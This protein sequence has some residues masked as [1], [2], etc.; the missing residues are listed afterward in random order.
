MPH[1]C[2][3]AYR[4]ATTTSAKA[5]GGA[6]IRHKLQESMVSIPPHCG[7][8]DG[9]RTMRTQ[10]LMLALMTAALLTACTEK[11][12]AEADRDIAKAQQKATQDVAEASKKAAEQVNEAKQKLDAAQAQATADVA[13]ANATAGEKIN[14]ATADATSA[15][16]AA[17]KDLASVQSDAFQKDAKAR[18][19]LAVA[20]AEADYKVAS[21]QCTA[22]PSGQQ[23]SCKD[24]AK[25][26]LDTAKSRAAKV[27]DDAE[28]SAKDLKN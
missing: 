25:S 26:D 14:A 5:H 1:D 20:K 2:A 6:F 21:E 13:K 24:A 16:R 15:E 19:D 9:E 11:S 23:G 4:A 17:N 18:Y 27:R 12:T 28:S 10:S 8:H 3:E 22:L 7:L